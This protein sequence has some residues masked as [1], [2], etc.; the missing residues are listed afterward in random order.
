MPGVRCERARVTSD[1]VEQLLADHGVPKDF[2]LLS[3]MIAGNDYWV[4][5]AVER[6]RPRI[7]AI[8]YNSQRPPPQRWV[9]QENASYRWDGTDYYGASLSSLADLGKRKGYSLVGSDSAGVNA[10]FVANEVATP[11]RFLDPAVQYYYS[12]PRF[13]PHLRGHPAG[14]GPFVEI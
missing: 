10:F 6:W 1:Y 2:D 11:G 8:Q 9:M 5:Q 7:V 14:A 12:P 13:G 3:V 4:W